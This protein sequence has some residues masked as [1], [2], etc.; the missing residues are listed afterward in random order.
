MEINQKTLKQVTYEH[1]KPDELRQA[2]IPAE[3]ISAARIDVKSKYLGCN[4]GLFYVNYQDKFEL[5]VADGEDILF[6]SR[7]PV[8]K[9]IEDIL[10]TKV[11]KGTNTISLKKAMNSEN[12]AEFTEKCKKYFKKVEIAKLYLWEIE[13]GKL[14]EEKISKIYNPQWF[15]EKYAPT[16]DRD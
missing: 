7:P 10:K 13:K 12:I 6:I 8:R 3:F 16:K 15:F 4:Y 1:L 9:R 2:E 14:L 5:S 11:K